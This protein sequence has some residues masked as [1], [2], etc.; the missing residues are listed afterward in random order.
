MK[1][2]LLLLSAQLCV[3]CGNARLMETTQDKFEKKN[4][5]TTAGKMLKYRIYFPELYQVGKSVPLLCFLHG[6]GERGSDNTSQLAHIA[7][8]LS[9]D[10]IQALYP[11]III[12]PQCPENKYWAHVDITENIWT[13]SMQENPTEP[14]QA[15]IELLQ[16]LET[17]PLIS[18][19]YV[20]GLSM[21]GF[22][23]LDLLARNLIDFSGAIAICGGGDLG[24]AENI[25]K[26]P[27]HI[28]HGAKDPVVPVELSRSIYKELKEKNS[29]VYYTEYLDGKHDVWNRAMKSE[30][31][32][33]WLF[34]KK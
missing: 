7:T 23:T 29:E 14:M 13:P 21:G 11:S 24:A 32:L 3:H 17:D 30:G 33:H 22:G 4:F 12:F 18:E 5:T 25:S 27:L 2:F 8:Y 31:L 6:A 15:V 1:L 9:S 20:A 16:S 19:K 10:S 28:F 34:S 26:V